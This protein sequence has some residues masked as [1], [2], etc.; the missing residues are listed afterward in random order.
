MASTPRETTAAYPSTTALGCL[1]IW[2]KS[3]PR[4]AATMKHRTTLVRRIAALL[5]TVIVEVAIA[6]RLGPFSGAATAHVQHSVPDVPATTEGDTCMFESRTHGRRRFGE[7]A[8]VLAV[9]AATLVLALS[10]LAP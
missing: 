2:A 3:S 1:S 10:A 7:T 6:S 5:S 9:G 8:Q 4:H